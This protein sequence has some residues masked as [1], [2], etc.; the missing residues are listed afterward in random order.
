MIV[1]Q[2]I[3]IEVPRPA[4]VFLHRACHKQDLDIE[5]GTQH[6][7]MLKASAKIR[8]VDLAT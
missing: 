1:P 2:H 3:K 6:P 5:E 4:Q 7:K 8:L